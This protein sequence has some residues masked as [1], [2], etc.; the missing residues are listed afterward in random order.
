MLFYK[1]SEDL[2]GFPVRYNSNDY[3]DN[4]EGFIIFKINL[5]SSEF[6]TYGEIMKTNDYSSNVQRIIYI[7]DILYELST[8]NVISYDLNTFEKLDEVE[9][10]NAE[11][12]VTYKSYEYE[13]MI[14]E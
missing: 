2:I 3:R 5:E 14:I 8:N 1:A 6:E 4:T 11:D 12:I 13:T 10:N 7:G 9:L